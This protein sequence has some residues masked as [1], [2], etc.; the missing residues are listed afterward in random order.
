MEWKSDKVSSLMKGLDGVAMRGHTDGE[1]KGT[2]L[3]EGC[4]VE[5]E[6]MHSRGQ[7]KGVIV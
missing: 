2:A 3:K 4:I 1:F 5:G 7:G 6:I